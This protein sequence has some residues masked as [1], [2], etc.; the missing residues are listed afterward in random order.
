VKKYILAV[1]ALAGFSMSLA[2]AP[3]QTPA[4]TAARKLEI[5][6]LGHTS[7]HH[8]SAK[9]AP[10]LKDALASEPFN[11][12]YTNDP[13]DLSEANLAKYD[14]LIIYANHTK[15]APEQ[16]KALLD[17]VAGGKGFLPLHSASFCFQ[18]SPDYIALVGAQFQKHKTGEFVT[19]IVQ[20]DHQVLLGIRPFKVWDETYVHAKHNNDRTVIMERVDETG[21]EP[22]TWTRSHGKGRVF[23][24]AYGHDERVW[25]HPSFH[26]LIRNAIY[27]AAPATQAQA[28]LAP[29]RRL[30]ATL[31]FRAPGGQD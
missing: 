23:Y 27:W 4:P 29:A 11:F 13:K 16:E 5:L 15:I 6:F 30:A 3:G 24:T 14:E 22:W 12:T 26:R 2:P 20:P 9:F 25:S 10:M 28:L 31:A 1:A 8:N 17:F 21:R 7:V 19:D 18:N